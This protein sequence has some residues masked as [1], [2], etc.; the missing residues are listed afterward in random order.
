[1]TIR[2]EGSRAVFSMIESL[3]RLESLDVKIAYPGHGSPFIN[4][5]EAIAK[6][7]KKMQTYLS[8][9]EKIGS[10]LL[11]KISIYTLLMQKTVAED[12]FFQQL[13][14]TFWFKETVDLYFDCQYE[15]KYA[16]VMKGFLQ[17]GIVKRENGK[18]Y[19]TI[20][21]S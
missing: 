10:D 14:S 6:S 9:R 15:Q 16:E 19:T 21:S 12:S 20:K 17:R 3:E 7:K 11:K 8:A 13:M 4:V 5:Q 18:L 2:V 1:M